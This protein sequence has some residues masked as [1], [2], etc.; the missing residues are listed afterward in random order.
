VTLTG[1]RYQGDFYPFPPLRVPTDYAIWIEDANRRHVRTLE[2]TQVAVSVGDEGS[3]LEHLPSWMASSGVTY[4]ALQQQTDA[5]IA[6]AFDGITSASPFFWAAM[7]EQTIELGWDL[8]NAAG[9][10]VKPGTYYACAEAANILKEGDRATNTTT[11]FEILAESR[12][13]KLDLKKGDYEADPPTA[14]IPQLSATFE[15]GAAKAVPKYI[16]GGE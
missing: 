16:F 11:R 6:P 5:G 14:H 9:E 13:L 12:C 8:K 10:R 15:K 4:A 2:I 3:H 1:P 7:E